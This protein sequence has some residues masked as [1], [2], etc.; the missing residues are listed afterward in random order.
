MKKIILCMIITLLLLTGCGKKENNIMKLECR[1]STT[2]ITLTI[3]GG[4]ITK[5]VDKISGEISQSEINL[6]NENYL[7]DID[8]DKDAISKMRE[9]IASN[10][11]DCK[12]YKE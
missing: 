8:N 11:G 6:L 7:S 1:L 3:E 9:V 2:T 4:K 5:Y 12:Q 10:G